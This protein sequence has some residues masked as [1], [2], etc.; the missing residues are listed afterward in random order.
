MWTGRWTTSSPNI[1]EE[2]APVNHPVTEL[3]PAQAGHHPPPPPPHSGSPNHPQSTNLGSPYPATF[4]ETI[5]FTQ[6]TTTSSD[7]LYE[8]I[9]MSQAYPT[10]TS[11]LG[12][13]R[14]QSDIWFGPIFPRRLHL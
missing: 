3:P 14:S 11:S 10:L 2:K 9:N 13:S 5:V 4:P 1:K 7:I 12:K 8:S 6:P